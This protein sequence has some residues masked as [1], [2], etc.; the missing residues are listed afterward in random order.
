[1]LTY[2]AIRE[3]QIQ[4][5]LRFHLI[6]HQENKNVGEDMDIHSWWKYKLLQPLLKK[7][8]GSSKN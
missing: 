3:M 2:L 6:F 1:M 8:G 4:T 7:F 5:I